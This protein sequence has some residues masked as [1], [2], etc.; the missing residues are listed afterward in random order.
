MYTFICIRSKWHCPLKQKS[1]LAPSAV[2]LG[3]VGFGFVNRKG[4]YCVHFAS[5]LLKR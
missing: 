3:R 2:R 1:L 4:L 5:V